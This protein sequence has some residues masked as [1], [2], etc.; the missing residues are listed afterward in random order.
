MPLDAWGKLRIA[1]WPPPDATDRPGPVPG[2]TKKERGHLMINR[3]RSWWASVRWQWHVR[4]FDK[5]IEANRK[6]HLPTRHI[7]A[8]RSDFLHHALRGG[9][10]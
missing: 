9:A 6:R 3:I 5:Q 8:A 4:H 10:R 1:A 7:V 2:R